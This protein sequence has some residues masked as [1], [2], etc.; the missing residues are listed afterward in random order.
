MD[1]LM[2][3]LE[4]GTAYNGDEVI[5]LGD[6]LSADE[7]AAWAGTISYEILTNINSRVPRLYL[8]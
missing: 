7:L 1:Q 2:V 4:W 8:V 5:L 6:S 3:N